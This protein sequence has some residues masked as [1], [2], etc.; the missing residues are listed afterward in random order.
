MEDRGHRV[1]VSQITN[2]DVGQ[3]K[4]NGKCHTPFVG[5]LPLRFD[6]SSTRTSSPNLT[7]P[8]LPAQSYRQSYL[9]CV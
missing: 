4:H 5:A 8:V 2:R 7:H 1:Q 3:G 9:A 6:F